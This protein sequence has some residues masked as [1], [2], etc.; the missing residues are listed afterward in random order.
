MRQFVYGPHWEREGREWPHREA[1]LF[2]VA[3]GLRWHVQVM[4]AG[5]VALLVHGTAAASHS[6]RGLAPLLAD[7]FEVVAPDLPGHGFTEMPPVG[8]MSLEGVANSLAMLLARLDKRPAL[9]IGHSAGAALLARQCLDGLIEPGCLISLNGALLPFPGLT[10]LAFSTTA[11][12][13]ALNPFLPHFVAVSASMPDAVGRLLRGTGSTIE[14]AGVDLYRRLVT[15]PRHVA[16]VVSMMANW[17]LDALERDLPRLDVP[18]YLVVAENDGAVPP[19]EAFRVRTRLPSAELIKVP[20]LGHLAHEERPDE[21]AGL[22]V[23]LAASRGI[24]ARETKTLP[25]PT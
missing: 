20:R 18:V 2:P 13:L 14:P 21:V 11:K 19:S 25:D 15:N 6:W 23:R 16:A 22:I 7:R 17:D 3:G 9:V 8:Q 5:P 1:S 10:G 24:L 4:G 12:L